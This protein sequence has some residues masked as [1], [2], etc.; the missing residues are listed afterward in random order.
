MHRRL[1]FEQDHRVE[2]M[3]WDCHGAHR[4]D[5]L[6]I[7]SLMAVRLPLQLARCT[8]GRPAVLSTCA[9]PPNLKHQ[10]HK[11]Q[12]ETANRDAVIPVEVLPSPTDFG[13]WGRWDAVTADSLHDF[14]LEHDC[15]Q[16]SAGRHNAW[17]QSA[18]SRAQPHC[19]GCCCKDSRQEPE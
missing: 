12:Q 17:L 18:A 6:P 10:Q 7:S 2:D 9:T 1:A 5:W 15:I 19:A 11:D 4:S 16:G 13:S 14:E 8:P 3:C